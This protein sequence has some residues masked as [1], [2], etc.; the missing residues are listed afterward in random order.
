[1]HIREKLMLPAFKTAERNAAQ[2]F[3]T[4]IFSGP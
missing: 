4:L 1:M 2:G 3:A